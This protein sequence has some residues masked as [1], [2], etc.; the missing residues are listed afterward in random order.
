M[1]VWFLERPDGAWVSKRQPP[2]ASQPV[3]FTRDP[4]A[5]EQWPTEAAADAVS[6]TA[7]MDPV[8]R[9]L[10]AMEHVFAAPIPPEGRS[11]GALPD[12]VFSPHNACCYRDSCRALAAHQPPVGGETERLREAVEAYLGAHG[13]V[14]VKADLDTRRDRMKAALRAVNALASTGSEGAES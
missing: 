6:K 7:V 3:V 5:A 1:S 10:R 2:I 9:E 12:G 8:W 13:A 14:A 4:N 11:A